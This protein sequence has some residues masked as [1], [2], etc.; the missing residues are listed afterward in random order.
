MAHMKHVT[1]FLLAFFVSAAFAQT[2]GG[3]T[4]SGELVASIQSGP[5]SDTGTWDCACIPG[6]SNEVSVLEGHTITVVGTDTVRAES[7]AIGESAVLTLPEGARL[8]VTAS[9]AS[10]GEVNGEGRVAFV[11]E[12]PHT[13]GPATLAN[14][15][16][17]MGD[18]TIADLVTITSDFD[19]SMADVVA[20]GLLVLDGAAG[21][22]S[23]GG[24]L[25]GGVVRRFDWTKTSPYTHQMGAGV[26]G[27]QASVLL[28]Q[29]GAVYVKEWTEASTSYL[30]LVGTD[31][32]KAG[33]G[34]TCSLPMG[35]YSYHFEGEAVLQADIE[36]TAEAASASW[37]GW[38]LLS[39]PLTG[40][41]DLAAT[42][43]TGPGSLGAVYQWVDTLQTWVAQVGGVG[44]FGRAGIVAPGDA[45]WTIADTAF[46]WSLDHGSL[47][48]EED[49]L[50]QGDALPESLLSLEMG[51]GLLIEQCAIVLGG[52]DEAYD[53]S[54]DAAF[55]SSFRGRNNLDIYSQTSDSISVM[56]NRTSDVGQSI[57]IWIKAGVGSLLSLEAPDIAPNLCLVLE[58][59]ETG[60]TVGIE[61]GFSYE[62]S[63][64]SGTDHHRFNVIVGSTM[65]ATATD[66][67]CESAQDGAITVVGPDL[68]TGFSLLDS[69]G[70]PAGT[71]SGDT[72][73]GT[74]TGLTA[75]TY[76]LTA[77][78]EGCA[79][80][81][82]V[83][84]VGAGGS[85]E[86]PFDIVAMPDHIGCYEILGGVTLDIEGGIEPYM[87]T[88]EHGA[89]GS[90]IEVDQAGVFSA[91][92]TDAA[93][94][95]DSTVV[96]V[97]AA[98]HV[99]A[100]VEVEDPVVS[101][102][103]GEAQVAFTNTSTGATSYQ[104]NFG[105]GNASPE[106]SPLHTYT[107]GGAYTVGLNAWN[108]YCSDTHQL[109]VTVE[110]V[111]SVGSLSTGTQP[112]LERKADGW[113]VVHPEESFVLHVFDLTGRQVHQV[114]GMAGVPVV[115]DAS[116]LPAVSLIR[117][118]GEISGRQKT[119]RL[120]R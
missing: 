120:A 38:N 26:S 58:D 97:L 44:Q 66:A 72:V 56:V 12:G 75:G 88:W 99:E 91:V 106:E 103:D 80:I 22:T 94:C 53:R 43:N 96:E 59:I 39:N 37:R 119:W 14:L 4:A 116:V 19:I 70:N 20:G 110:V 8:E 100:G 95:E 63:P 85:G 17:G 33:A 50:D 10:V 5:W 34:F 2:G 81:V 60:L 118:A 108:D 114:R 76:T 77:I 69:Q 32:L 46:T 25:T 13:C 57:P 24:T 104:W 15:D 16:C 101:L 109:V 105:D 89:V 51:N 9:M 45:F 68:T 98:P 3:N 87:V 90:T 55:T 35:T 21:I 11:G 31:E 82:R 102:I 92:I 29:P 54:E 1:T 47:V 84:E 30:S 41:V 61:P 74:F 112:I 107:A 93:G 52:G 79:D 71:F 117:W 28:E 78:T 6:A 23:S 83:L 36:V 62:F 65:T 115:L 7:I 27:T 48:E 64:T 49:W 18:M 42:T 113:S 40:F 73:S 111:S 86:T 67:A